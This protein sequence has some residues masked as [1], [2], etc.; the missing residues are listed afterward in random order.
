M[1]ELSILA[2]LAL[3][4]FSKSSISNFFQIGLQQRR[5]SLNSQAE[6]AEIWPFLGFSQNFVTTT[7]TLLADLNKPSGWLCVW[8][9]LRCVDGSQPNVCLKM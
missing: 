1:F 7:N 6:T 9:A 3:Q 8:I 5:R 4:I 2:E